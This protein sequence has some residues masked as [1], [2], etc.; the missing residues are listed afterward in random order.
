VDRA[1]QVAAELVTI[2][3]QLASDWVEV[4]LARVMTALQPYRTSA[5]VREVAEAAR[6]VLGDSPR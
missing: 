1:C 5:A 2:T 6:P 4:E 3:G